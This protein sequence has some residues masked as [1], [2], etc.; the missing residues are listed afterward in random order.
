MRDVPTFSAYAMITRPQLRVV[1]MLFVWGVVWSGVWNWL[2]RPRPV[3]RIE[4]PSTASLLSVSDTGLASVVMDGAAP[5]QMQRTMSKV[6]DMKTG[7]ESPLPYRPGDVPLGY[8]LSYG[9]LYQYPCFVL[10]DGCV[11]QIDTI[12]GEAIRRYE[13]LRSAISVQTSPDRTRLLIQQTPSSY[14]LFDVAT[15]KVAWTFSQPEPICLYWPSEEFLSFYGTRV[16]GDFKVDASTGQTVQSGYT[17]SHLQMA[18]I[19]GEILSVGLYGKTELAVYKSDKLWLKFPFISSGMGFPDRKQLRFSADGSSLLLDYVNKSG[20]VATA[21]WKLNELEV[22]ERVSFSPFKVALKGYVLQT[23]AI[24]LPMWLE[25]LQRNGR[26]WFGASPAEKLQSTVF[27]QNGK[28]LLQVVHSYT[29]L[30]Y[31]EEFAAFIDGGQGIVVY[32]NNG[33]EYYRVPP[34]GPRTMPYWL[35]LLAP[36]LAWWGIRR[37]RKPNSPPATMTV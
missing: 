37:I 25:E 13:E 9:L 21:N 10:R 22:P 27:D 5:I 20:K 29:D 11:H 3:T 16:G 32:N 17:R 33:L 19:N 31:L 6:W 34:H 28:Q 23:R 26:S 15:K 12:T 2:S 35:G 1:L 30:V 18:K 36:P 14:D 24:E 4:L 8:G 7:L